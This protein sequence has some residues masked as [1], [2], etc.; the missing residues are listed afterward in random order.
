MGHRESN[1]KREVHSAKDL[2]QG[3][4]KIQQSNSTLEKQKLEKEQAKIKVSRGK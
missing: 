4:R 3:T 2:P 1:S